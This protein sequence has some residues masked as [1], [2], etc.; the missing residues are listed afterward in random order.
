MHH[1]LQQRNFEQIGKALRFFQDICWV[2]IWYVWNFRGRLINGHG[3]R[4][5]NF[6]VTQST[7][8]SGLAQSV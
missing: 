3:F 2:K 5:A 6:Q 8:W 1:L 4:L 7:G